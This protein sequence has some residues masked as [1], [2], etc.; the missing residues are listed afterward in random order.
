MSFYGNIGEFFL[1]IQVCKL[2][3]CERRK[4]NSSSKSP[5]DTRFVHFISD[6]HTMIIFEKK[7]DILSN[8]FSKFRII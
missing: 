5:I 3:V 6:S 7:Y 1:F 4:K 8:S 2:Y